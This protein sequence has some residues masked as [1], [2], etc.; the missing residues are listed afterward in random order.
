M[1]YGVAPLSR[2]EATVH[3]PPPAVGNPINSAITARAS[4]PSAFL[5]GKAARAVRHAPGVAHSYCMNTCATVWNRT[6]KVEGKQQAKL[7]ICKSPPLMDSADASVR[8]TRLGTGIERGE[9]RPQETRPTAGPLVVVRS[10]QTGH[11]NS[12]DAQRSNALPL[13]SAQ[14]SRVQSCRFDVARSA[15]KSVVTAVFSVVRSSAALDKRHGD[16]EVAKHLS[17]RWE[18]VGP[19]REDTR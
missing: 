4:G 11:L 16:S 12:N 5:S 19:S 1:T 18:V 9:K 17:C 3:H 10:E 15:R 13:R 7:R 8:L 2:S 14:P 6:H